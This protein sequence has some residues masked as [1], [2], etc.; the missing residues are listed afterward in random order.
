M[1]NSFLGDAEDPAFGGKKM[2]AKNFAIFWAVFVTM[3]RLSFNIHPWP[4]V[5]F[6]S[7]DT[8]QCAVCVC[9]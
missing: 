9:I 1:S 8:V 2:I 4:Y 3:R 5:K 6:M 7:P